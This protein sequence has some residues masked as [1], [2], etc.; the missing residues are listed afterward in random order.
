MELAALEHLEL[1]DI[2]VT[3][4]APSF[5]IGSSLFL[6]VKRSFIKASMGSKFGQIRPWPLWLA[7]LERL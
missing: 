4:L 2:V 7:A 1:M 3:T 5:F 6:Q